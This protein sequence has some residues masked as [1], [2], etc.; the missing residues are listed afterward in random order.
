MVA[1][2]LTNHLQLN[3]LLHKHQF[4]F[5]RNLSTEHNLTHVINFIGS[6]LNKG[7]YCIGIF[8]DLRKAFD[9]VSHSI[10]LKKL[11]KLGVSGTALN[12][13]ACYLNARTQRVDV[14]S[15]MSDLL[16]ITCGVFQGSILGPILF[17]CYIND[18]FNATDLATFLFADDTS[19]MA[20]SN[21]LPDLVNYVNRELN[22][23]AVWFKANKLAVN[24]CKTNYMIFHAKGKKV[25]LNGLE[26]LFN[27]N[28]PNATPPDPN[29]I[30]ALERIHDNNPNEKL[31]SFKLLGVFLDEHLSLSKHITHICSKLSRANFILRRV[32]N[33]LPQ[34]CLRT[35]YFSLFHSHLLYCTNIVSCASQSNLNRVSLLQR[36]AIRIIT[37]SSYNDHTGPLF[38]SLRILPFDKIIQLNR[39]LFMHSVTYSYAPLSFHDTWSLNENRDLNYDLR[40]RDTFLTPPVRIEL[41]RKIPLYS[42]PT[43]WNNLGEHIRLQRNRTTFKIALTDFLFDNILQPP[44]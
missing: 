14:N 23:L 38:L 31:R 36:K 22:K 18:I 17:L 10:L 24:V 20:E 7:N 32:N 5:Q 21:N 25:E 4:G 29:L 37:K 42:L 15:H 34:K 6:A 41:F 30:C 1:V 16:N 13:F 28:D 2:R 27:S 3:K 39:L 9:T 35:L 11:Q 26:I 40:N 19:C 44:L 12:W 43:E 8:L 33:L